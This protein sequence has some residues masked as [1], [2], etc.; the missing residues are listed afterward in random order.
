[1]NRY[2]FTISVIAFIAITATIGTAMA[3]LLPVPTDVEVCIRRIEA[4]PPS[5]GSPNIVIGT[6]DLDLNAAGVDVIVHLN[7]TSA[8]GSSDT[9]KGRFCQIATDAIIKTHST[10][11]IVPSPL[12]IVP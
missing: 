6:I 11:I 8:P 12:P 5:A 9:R 10:V 3:A 7:D 4:N 1:M 2:A